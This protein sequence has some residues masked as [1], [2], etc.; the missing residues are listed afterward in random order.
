VDCKG[1][2]KFAAAL[3]FVDLYTYAQDH[4]CPGL[5]HFEAILGSDV[6]LPM[7]AFKPARL[8]S[9]FK[10]NELKPVTTDVDTFSAFSF[11]SDSL[12]NLK[13]EL[14]SYLTKAA[15]VSPRLLVGGDIFLWLIIDMCARWR[16]C[17]VSPLVISSKA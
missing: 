10:V 2:C 6:S 1:K 9:P 5:Q 15:D 13:T 17:S 11:L 16:R 7:S 12:N 8:F 3:N 4:I 14:A